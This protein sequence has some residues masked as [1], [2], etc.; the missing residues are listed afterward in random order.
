[1]AAKI[2]NNERKYD[3]YNFTA[4]QVLVDVTNLYGNEKLSEP[5]K[6]SCPL[7]SLKFF[8][9][10]PT[11]VQTVGHDTNNRGTIPY[12]SCQ[13]KLTEMNSIKKIKMDKEMNDILEQTKN[14]DPFSRV[15][16]PTDSEELDSVSDMN[17][18]IGEEYY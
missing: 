11:V 1:M 9:L 12:F 3:F 13:Y 4:F 2:E 10:H 16:K 15:V 14:L 17:N 8:P 18:D 7:T 6:K 5:G